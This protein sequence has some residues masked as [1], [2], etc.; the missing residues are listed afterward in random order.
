M[1]E[2]I[3]E[4]FLDLCVLQMFDFIFVKVRYV[5]VV[6][7]IKLIMNDNGFVCLKKVCYLLFLF[8]QVV[9]NDIEFGGD[10]LIIVIIGLNIGGKIV[11]FKMLGLLILMV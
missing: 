9:V 4:F 7:V 5:K 2:Y 11:I 10:F 8:D 1:V 6:K 3:E